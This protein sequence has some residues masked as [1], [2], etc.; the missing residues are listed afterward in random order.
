[1]KTSLP[2]AIVTESACTAFIGA[3]SAAIAVTR[4]L[5]TDT[6]NTQPMPAADI[7]RNRK[8][9]PPRTWKTSGGV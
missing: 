2:P 9:C 6:R 7:I 8:R 5:S 4:C 1:M 3:P